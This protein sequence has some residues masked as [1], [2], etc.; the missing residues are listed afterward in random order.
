MN[1][2][3][4]A[5]GAFFWGNREGKHGWV[6]S[7]DDVLIGAGI[8]GRAGGPIHNGNGYKFTLLQP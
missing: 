5:P 1:L 3:I 8:S 7:G 2:D 6:Y 4:L